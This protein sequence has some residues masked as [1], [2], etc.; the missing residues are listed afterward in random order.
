MFKLII[1]T[2]DTVSVPPLS[3]EGDNFQ[4]QILKRGGGRGGREKS[5]YLRGLKEFLPWIFALG[6]LIMF[7]VRKR[8]KN[9]IWL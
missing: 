6:G 3:D 9:K 4:F 1:K 2:P 8:L 5:E 7:L